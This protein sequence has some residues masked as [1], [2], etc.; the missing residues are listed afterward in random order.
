MPNMLPFAP[1]QLKLA[2]W[3]FTRREWTLIKAIGVLG[4]PFF[5]KKRLKEFDDFYYLFILVSFRSIFSR[6]T[7]KFILFFNLIRL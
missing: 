6:L 4:I 2:Q 1:A 3:V 7:C 5:L